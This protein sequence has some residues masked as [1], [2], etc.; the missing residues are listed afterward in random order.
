M[1]LSEF[2]RFLPF[3]YLAVINVAAFLFMMFD[4]IRAKKE[5][6][7]IRERTLFLLAILGGS[8]GSLAGMYLFR[9]KTKHW[10]F[11][12]GMPLILIAQIALVIWFYFYQF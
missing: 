12:V 6:W 9:H 7:R 4:K 2:L 8:I 10:Y 1:T 3:I 5:T 11:V